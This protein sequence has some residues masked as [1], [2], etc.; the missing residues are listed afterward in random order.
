M[1]I[2]CRTADFNAYHAV[3]G[4]AQFDGVV[5]FE[6]AP[7]TRP[8]R[9]RIVFLRGTG[10]G[11]A[12]TDAVIHA[13]IF[14]VVVFTGKRP[15]GATLTGDAVLLLGQLRFPFSVGFDDFWIG[16][17]SCLKPG[18]AGKVN[19]DGVGIDRGLPLTELL[20]LASTAVRIAART[21]WL[22]R[23]DICRYHVFFDAAPWC[24]VFDELF[25]FV[26]GRDG[27]VDKAAGHKPVF[28]F[29]D[30]GCAG[31]ASGIELQ[32]AAHFFR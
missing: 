26:P 18:N 21:L 20:R 24:P 31:H 8:T 27:D 14:V 32:V 7:E 17:Q 15:F 2:A 5:A 13:C 22:D 9:T 16:H 4:V 28:E 6:R 29:V 23:L 11:F 10:Q 25:R 19:A 30:I 3:T 12:T 1:G